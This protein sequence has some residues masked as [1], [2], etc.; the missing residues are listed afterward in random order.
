MINARSVKTTEVSKKELK[1]GLVTAKMIK[2]KTK[3]EIVSKMKK[4]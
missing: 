3:M 4:I 1:L 2:M